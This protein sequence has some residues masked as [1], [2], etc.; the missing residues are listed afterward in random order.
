MRGRLI[1]IATLIGAIVGSPILSDGSANAIPEPAAP[2]GFSIETVL[3]DHG[4]LTLPTAVAFAPDGTI[5]VAEKSGI[6]KRFDDPDDSIPQIFA[7]MSTEVYDYGDKGLLGLAVDPMFL[8]GRPYVYAAYS[9]DAPPGQ[10][11]PYWGDAC[12]AP[13]SGPADGCTTT[14]KVVRLTVVGMSTM[15]TPITLIHDQWCQ[16]FATNT[17]GHVAVGPDGYLYVSSGE[18]S[19]EGAVDYGQF[20]TPSLNPCKDPGGTSP[21][22]AQGGALRSQDIATIADAERLDGAVIRVDPDTGIGASSN[23]FGGAADPNRRRVIAYGLHNPSR[24]TFRP[25]TN[26]VWIADAGR[27]GHEEINKIASP[28]TPIDNFGWPCYEGDAPQASYQAVGLNLCN[29]LYASG[30]AQPPQFSYQHN[31]PVISGDG[32][33][34]SRSEISAIEF[35]RGGDYPAGFDG[36]MFAV[37]KFRKCVW[38][39]RPNLVGFPDWDKRQLFMAHD[40]D[41]RDLDVGPSGDLFWVDSAGGRVE[42]LKYS[43]SNTAPAARIIATPTSG[44]TPLTV[45]FDS[46]GS[47]DPDIGDRIVAVA[48]DLDGDGSFDDSTATNPVWSYTNPS[49][50]TVSLRVTDTADANGYDTVTIMPSATPPELW[51]LNPANHTNGDTIIADDLY[52]IGDSVSFTGIAVDAEDGV[53][54]ASNYRWELTK[55]DCVSEVECGPELLQTFNN[56]ATASFVIPAHDYPSHLELKFVAT[57]SA[58]FSSS[59]VVRFGAQPASLTV[60]SEPTGAEVTVDAATVTTPYSATVIA[61]SRIEVSG[62]ATQ[63][64]AGTSHDWVSTSGVGPDGRTVTVSSAGATAHITY[65]PTIR[66]VIMPPYR[67]TGA[68]G[69]TFNFAQGGRTEVAP[70]VG[71]GFTTVAAASNPSRNGLWRV[72]AGGRVKVSGAAR[73]HGTITT[74]QQV[75]PVVDIESTGTGDG[76]WLLLA[77]GNVHAFGD[78]TNFGHPTGPQVRAHAVGLVRTPDSAGYWVA[79]RRGDVYKFG[80]AAR[81]GS[82]ANTLHGSVLGIAAVPNAQGYWILS[83]PG[84]VNAFGA[85]RNFGSR[86][87]G[88]ST[89]AIAPTPTGSGYW[90]LGSGGTIFSFGDAF[91]LGNWRR[92]QSAVALS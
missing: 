92:P 61:N 55:H 63:D 75:A 34:T 80:N 56:L 21:P 64:I 91:R 43:L 31:A 88:V 71:G 66:P 86:T 24:F 12:P 41:I 47:H 22:A 38:L 87:S 52:S 36:A 65:S 40:R 16:Q 5:F 42:R 45:S 27:T 72:G 62:A 53:V 2:V 73:F 1:L 69:L 6:I 48:W 33:T 74:A 39:V 30:A 60:T 13:I 78:A 28:A 59:K 57:D 68:D 17:I 15:T 79:S 3:G 26:E 19:Y 81:L 70:P 18:G 82:L 32:C 51:I 49:P 35:Y 37:D 7:D 20:A 23:P 11:A 9:Y 44:S 67:I 25:G 14:A 85:A 84:I 76:Y 83:D 46:S 10:V 50:V 58:G 8:D 4:E 77:N 29:S 90:I 89:V 54:N